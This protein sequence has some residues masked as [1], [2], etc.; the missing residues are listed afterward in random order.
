M[1]AIF[2]HSMGVDLDVIPDGAPPQEPVFEGDPNVVVRG[3][4]EGTE[5]IEV[6]GSASAGT[7]RAFNN[8]LDCFVVGVS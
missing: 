1:P 6:L 4:Q 7:K 5:G 3:I 8:V 2:S